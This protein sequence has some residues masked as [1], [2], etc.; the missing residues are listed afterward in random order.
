MIA[1]AL[2]NWRWLLPTIA[3]AFFALMWG[4]T[5][6]QYSHLKTEV[7]ENALK[8][9]EAARLKDAENARLS[10]QIEK[11]SHE[12]STAIDDKDA[13]LR[14]LNRTRGMY[15][16]IKADLSRSTS[17]PGNP[18]DGTIEARLSEGDGAFLTT[19]ARDCARD[20]SVG[21]AGSDFA[22]TYGAK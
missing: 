11:A 16:R 12:R 15:V 2:L 3:A 6:L 20:Q 13:A 8:A 19:F 18:S 22:N 5:N 14:E 4:W 21:L 17:S 10:Q 1:F 7:A 9:S